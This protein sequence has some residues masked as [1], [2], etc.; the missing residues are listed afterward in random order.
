M[1]LPS[2]LRRA[3]VIILCLFAIYKTTLPV[4]APITNIRE[5]EIILVNN[6]I[7]ASK[8]SS[9]TPNFAVLGA[10]I[11]QD[12]INYLLEQELGE[13]RLKEICDI[14]SCESNWKHEGVWGDNGKAYGIAQFWEGTFYWL[15]ELAGLEKPNWKS[16][17][18]QLYLLNWA[19]D[20]G[21]ANNWT[22]YRKLQ[23]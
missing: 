6:T 13:K 11:S 15:A 7:I 16:K 9:T 19:L 17:E 4:K 14:V 12:D 21:H 1:E 8:Y 20:N 18:Q 22:C 10:Y 5:E 3:L 2:R 23:K